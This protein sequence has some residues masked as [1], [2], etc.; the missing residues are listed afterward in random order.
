VAKRRRAAALQKSDGRQKGAGYRKGGAGRSC[1]W[2]S[3]V[4]PPHSK[5]ATAGKKAQGIAEAAPVNNIGQARF[6]AA[7]K[8]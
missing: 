2:Q 5:K 1:R 8:N 3:G 7:K 4:E 6:G